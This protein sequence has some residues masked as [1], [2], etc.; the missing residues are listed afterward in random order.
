MQ[1]NHEPLRMLWSI[2]WRSSIADDVRDLP[3]SISNAQTR[4]LDFLSPF[5]G[6]N[7]GKVRGAER[8]VANESSPR[9]AS[10][11]VIRPRRH[12]S[13]RP[14]QQPLFLDRESIPAQR[15]FPPRAG[16]NHEIPGILSRQCETSVIPGTVPCALPFFIP[17]AIPLRSVMLLRRAPRTTCLAVTLTSAVNRADTRASSTRASR[18]LWNQRN[19]ITMNYRGASALNRTKTCVN[20]DGRDR[21]T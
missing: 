20:V 12:Y 14:V 11:E 17:R 13:C 6:K 5:L 8:I 16:I 4:P 3:N 7:G 18:L 1:S 10:K 9:H 15:P 21:V 2:A 19:G